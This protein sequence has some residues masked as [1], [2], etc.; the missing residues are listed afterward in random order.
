MHFST[1]IQCVKFEYTR[2]SHGKQELD[3]MS[4]EMDLDMFFIGSGGSASGNKCCLLWEGGS[5]D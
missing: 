5:L 4:N 3:T 1:T 2:I